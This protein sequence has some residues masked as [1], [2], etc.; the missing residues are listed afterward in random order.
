MIAL[1]QAHL[2]FTLAVFLLLAS[3]TEQLRVRWAL[4]ALAALLSVCTIDGLSLAAYVRSFTDDTAITSL[5]L[6]GWLALRRLGWPTA[7]DGQK[8]LALAVIALLAVA[9]YPATLGL[10][11]FDPYR[12]GFNPRPLILGVALLS[13]ALLYLGNALAVSL[14]GAATLAFALR[15]KPSENYWDYLVDPLIALYACGAVLYGLL[16]Q[17]WLAYRPTRAEG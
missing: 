13:F 6:L 3:F 5:V 10:T 11:Y 2:A 15:L 1:W 17:G 7:G 4:L 9:L 12:W 14:L 16:R 8:P